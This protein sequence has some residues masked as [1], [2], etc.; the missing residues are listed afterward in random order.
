MRRKSAKCIERFPRNRG[1]SERWILSSPCRAPIGVITVGNSTP[2][3][4]RIARL[5]QPQ[6]PG[7]G[8]IY[9]KIRSGPAGAI[10]V[11]WSLG[12]SGG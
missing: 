9:K 6:L 11:G 1:Y 10:R 8:H 4:R 2:G 5:A 7:K 3:A 12:E